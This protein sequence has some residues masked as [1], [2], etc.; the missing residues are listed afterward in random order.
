MGC[1]SASAVIHCELSQREKY[2]SNSVFKRRFLRQKDFFIRKSNI[3]IQKKKKGWRKKRRTRKRKGK[4]KSSYL[5]RAGFDIS[6][7]LTESSSSSFSPAFARNKTPN[8]LL[9]DGPQADLAV[10]SPS[11]CL[12]LSSLPVILGLCDFGQVT[13]RLRGLSP[14]IK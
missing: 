13:H 1:G 9:S 3:V 4:K 6:K 10:P 12:G 2:I 7:P 8:L 14:S 5:D 11:E